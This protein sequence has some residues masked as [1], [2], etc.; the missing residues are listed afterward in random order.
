MDYQLI[1]FFFAQKY[2]AK[3]ELNDNMITA[4]NKKLMQLNFKVNVIIIKDEK[5]VALI[6]IVDIQANQIC[7]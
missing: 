3:H 5:A 4:H 7:L 2:E 1:H 6:V